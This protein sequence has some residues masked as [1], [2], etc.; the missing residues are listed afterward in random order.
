MPHLGWGNESGWQ[1][2]CYPHPALIELFGLDKRHKYKKGTQKEKQRG[3]I[4]LAEYIQSLCSSSTLSL[5]IPDAFSA[6]LDAKH[7]QG[8]SGQGLKHNEDALD[9]LICL[10]IAAL[11]AIGKKMVVFGDSEKGYIVVPMRR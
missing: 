10:Y 9:A 3:Q 2:E 5:Q 6:Y 8:L 4:E 7:I 1:I 11:Y